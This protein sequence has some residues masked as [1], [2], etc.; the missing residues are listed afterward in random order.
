MTPKPFIVGIGHVARVGKDTAASALQKE[1]GFTRIGFADQLRELAMGADPLATATVRSV[2][3]SV[4]HGRLA[5]VV[6]GLGYEAAKDSYP[7]VRRFLQNLGT[8]ART[9]FGE[10]FWVDQL[11]ARAKALGA[12]RIVIPDVRYKNEAAAI[13]ARG[14]VLIRINRPGAVGYGHLSETDL[15]DYTGWDEEFT[16]NTDVEALQRDVVGFVKN[17]L[18]GRK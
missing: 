18:E 11:F 5:W 9:T 1:L 15:K 10:D 16:N 3:V 6:Q 17:I 8:A 2:N 4:G 12:P 7:E 14:G 13:K